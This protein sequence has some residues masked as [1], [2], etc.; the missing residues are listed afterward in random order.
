MLWQEI[1]AHVLKIS[2]DNPWIK[3]D[4]RS[5]WHRMHLNIRNRTACGTKIT[6]A[7]K[8]PYIH[9]NTTAPVA[10]QQCVICQF[11]LPGLH[12]VELKPISPTLT[13]EP[14]HA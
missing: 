5:I 1:I 2:S 7:N 6:N 11:D 13:Q 3:E 14:I 8:I 10:V 12:A 9:F 4:S